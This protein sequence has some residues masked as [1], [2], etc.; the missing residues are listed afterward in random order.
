[1]HNMYTWNKQEGFAHDI[2]IYLVEEGF[3]VQN[4]P[5]HKISSKEIDYRSTQSI[6]HTHTYI[7]N[8]PSSQN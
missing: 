5:G 8:L 6:T 4:V 3:Q 1:M 2:Y 7:Y